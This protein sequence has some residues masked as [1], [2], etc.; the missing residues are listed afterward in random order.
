MDVERT[1]G[2][3]AERISNEQLTYYFPDVVVYSYFTSN[4]KCRQKLPFTSWDVTSDT[5]TGIDV[6]LRQPPLV[7]EAGVDLT[8]FKKIKGAADMIDHYY[9]VSPDD[10]GFAIEAGNKYITGYH[11]APGTKHKDLRCASTNQR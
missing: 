10:D 8:K 2:P 11:Y 6:N 7:K 9:Y 3:S 1:L 4:P 5:L